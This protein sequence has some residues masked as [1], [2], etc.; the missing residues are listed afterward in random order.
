[1]GRIFHAVAA[2]LLAASVAAGCDPGCANRVLGDIP[3][4]DARHHAVIFMRSCGATTDV[5]TQISVL[6]AGRSPAGAGN[7]FVA[8]TDHGRAPAGPGGGPTVAV[9]WLDGHTL[10]VRYDHRARVFTQRARS[11]GTDLR[12]LP[13]SV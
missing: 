12:F 6:P 10:E 11:N 1:L 8:D 4:P 13:D 2:S 9:R 3:A 5:S 7:V